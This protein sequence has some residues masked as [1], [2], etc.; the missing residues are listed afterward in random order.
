MASEYDITS[1]LD[2]LVSADT[3]D[4]LNLIE[5]LRPITRY[6]IDLPRII[7]CGDQSAGKSSVLEAIS[8]LNFPRSQGTC[9]TFATEVVLV[10][11]P[12]ST[13]T[14]SI[15]WS[16][17]DHE[18][19]PFKSDATTELHEAIKT[20]K[21]LMIA[22]NRGNNRT[23][24]K[25]V[26][27]IRVSDPEFAPLILV[28]LPGLMKVGPEKEIDAVKDMIQHHMKREHTIIL[29]V[30]SAS[31]DLNNQEILQW[32]RNDE[33][34]RRRAMGI[35]TKPDMVAQKS[36]S[37]KAL[38]KVVKENKWEKI[39]LHHGWHVVRN[40]GEAV[41]EA[42]LSFQER[43]KNETDYFNGQY[44]VEGQKGT[45]W[46]QGLADDQVGVGHLRSKLCKIYEQHTRAT[47][48]AMMEVLE[49]NI[50]SCEGK[51]EL[52]GKSRSDER[53]KEIYLRDIATSL[54]D[55]IR[56]ATFGNYEG[57]FQAFF[58]PK[59]A[60][61]RTAIREANEAFMHWMLGWGHTEEEENALSEWRGENIPGNAKV[62]VDL[63]QI[64]TREERIERVQRI[65][66]ENMT[67][68]PL[69]TFNYR[70]VTIL[71]RDKSKRWED[72]AKAH[73]QHVWDLTMSFFTKALFHAA[74]NE[75]TAER[76]LKYLIKPKMKDI[77]KALLL[78]V[79][80]VIRPHTN[81][82]ALSYNPEFRIRI[83]K[84]FENYKSKEWKDLF[85]HLKLESNV[86][87]HQMTDA[88]GRYLSHGTHY[89]SGAA[90][91]LDVSDAHYDVSIPPYWLRKKSQVNPQ[92]AIRTFIENVNALVIENCLMGNLSEIFTS[93]KVI[94]IAT[95]D[96][97]LFELLA[98]EPA[99]IMRD[100]QFLEEKKNVLQQAL[101]RCED[102][103]SGRRSSRPPSFVIEASELPS[104]GSSQTSS[105]RSH[106]RQASRSS[107]R[108][109]GISTP[110]SV[111]SNETT[112]TVPSTVN[113]PTPSEKLRRKTSR[114]PF[115]ESGE[116][117]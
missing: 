52:L 23:I 73:V 78:K 42:Q 46:G 108:G 67:N 47:L 38:V 104:P 34:L 117:N 35:L 68:E 80:E 99:H 7:V 5:E 92:V 33:K 10:R 71:F 66:R 61:L 36:D 82:P 6:N 41:G 30:L 51:L 83:R 111:R 103:H 102:V 105:I 49:G 58:G 48:P 20:A 21:N 44:G 90:Q 107:R 94:D 39:K 113:T 54:E 72:V 114:Q 74:P 31:Q 65:A 11:A 81:H 98:G 56:E 50:N 91:L 79:Q 4:M 26:L 37:E 77:Q 100:R 27:Q 16:N 12:K 9:T 88:V 75:H 70:I 8:R 57:K 95:D 15:L 112:L 76:L 110:E 22:R 59:H 24:H 69:G 3:V 115:V 17:G 87:S 53:D 1:A 62:P 84:N 101:K 106:V 28:D 19:V 64:W 14:V 18:M 25:D 32:L 2:G 43:D 97:E 89:A 96:P 93:N 109:S 116:E 40:R 13:P 85:M 86:D 45:N 55:I 29:A 63:P 60:K